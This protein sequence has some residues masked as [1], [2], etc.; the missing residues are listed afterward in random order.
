LR[1]IIILSELNL[2]GKS[3]QPEQN[4]WPRVLILNF[5]IYWKLKQEIPTI[6]YQGYML[7]D[8]DF[9]YVSQKTF[10]TTPNFQI[11]KSFPHFCRYFYYSDSSNTFLYHDAT[12]DI[13]RRTAFEFSTERALESNFETTALCWF[14]K[15]RS[16]C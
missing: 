16:G 1:K 3:K 7:L 10:N 9:L 8:N 14:S 2:E 15:S 6:L 4:Y 12:V 5:L 13:R 11:W